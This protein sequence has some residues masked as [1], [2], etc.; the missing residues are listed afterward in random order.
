VHA[1]KP[2]A[3]LRAIRRYLHDKR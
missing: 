3:V 1:E 2:E